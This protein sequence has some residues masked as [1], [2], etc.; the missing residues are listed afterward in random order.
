[1]EHYKNEEDFFSSYVQ[2][3]KQKIDMEKDKS[4]LMTILMN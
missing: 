3:L 2:R 1:M 4:P